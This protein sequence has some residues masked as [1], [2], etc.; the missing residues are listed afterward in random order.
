MYDLAF[1][2]ATVLD[3]TGSP[4]YRADVAVQHGRIADIGERLD[5]T[6]VID[7]DGRV[8]SPGF[9]DMHAHSDLAVLAEPEHLAKISQGVTTEVLGQDGLSYAPITDPA[10]PLLR[11][12]IAGWNG[13]PEFDI[14]WRTVAEYLA[15]L[16]RGIAVN[17]CYLVPQGTVRLLAVG[18]QNRPPTDAELTEQQTLIADGLNA[19]AVGL[20]SGLTYLPGGYADDD[21]LVALCRVVAEHG[22]FFAPHHRS[23]G[24]GALTAYADMIA[25]A[26]RAGCAL[27][28][29]HATMNF[30]LNAGRAGELLALLD[31]ASDVDLSLDSYPYTAGSTTLAALLPSWVAEGGPAAIRQ[32][33]ENPELCERIQHDLEV[34]GSDGCHGVPVDWATIR[35]SGTAD[36][37]LS[38]AVGRT[39]AEL[40]VERGQAAMVVFSQLLLDDSL[41]TSI[42]QH[43]GDEANVQQIMTHS[44]H[45]GG[46]DGLLVGA[47]PHPR[48]W[49][50]FPRYLGRYVRELGVLSLPEAIAH[51]TG[52]PARRLRLVRRGQIQLGWHADLVLFDPARVEDRATFENPRAQSVGIE[53][54]LV[55]GVLVL[56]DG[57]STGDRP[58]HSLRA[59]TGGTR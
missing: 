22:G 43:V 28:L 11:E 23:Y 1:R 49:G 44:A 2:G 5:A 59:G 31:S 57:R 48:A 40:A 55:N 29:A 33:L 25:V 18:W 12:Q 54:V 56:D 10:L 9:I 46:S 3:G 47:R 8:L 6:R 45:T 16:D 7:A 17:A 38:G 13:Y 51:L 58:G 15:E 42:T 37:T 39:V 24:A 53:Q 30:P 50:T 14:S 26:R 35:I 34:T 41:A 19:G 32:R 20:S 21:E 36:P 4:G 27:H 52:R